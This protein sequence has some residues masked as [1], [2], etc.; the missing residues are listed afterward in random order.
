MNS[1]TSE[2]TLE[3]AMLKRALFPHLFGAENELNAFAVLDGAAAPDLLD[4]LYGDPRPEFICLYRGD[5]EPDIAEIA[6]YLVR[7]EPGHP[8]T[9]WLLAEGWGKHWGIFAVSAA[10]LKTIRTHL[11]KFL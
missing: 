5:L 8:F 7:L 1:T 10:G 3:P 4:Q 11:R 2:L 6:P 9:D